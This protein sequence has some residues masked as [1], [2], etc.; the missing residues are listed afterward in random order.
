M[1]KVIWIPVLLLL[2]SCS[3]KPE[4]AGQNGKY[5]QLIMA[6]LYN[7]YAA[8]YRA[9]AYQAFNAA[10]WRVDRVANDQPDRSHLAIVLDIDETVLDNSP[11]QARTINT[12]IGYPACWDEWCNMAGAQ[13]VPGAVE[14]LTHADSLGFAIFYIS[15]RKEKTTYEGTARN[16]MAQGFPQ[17]DSEHLLLRSEPGG[18][19]PNPSDKEFRR[20]LLREKGYEIVLLA[21]D[22]LGDFFSDPQAG[23]DRNDMVNRMKDLYGSRFIIL[24]NAMYGNWPASVGINDERKS[25]DSLLHIMTVKL[26]SACTIIN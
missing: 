12:G 14:F 1:K 25:I 7:Y 21:G 18:P 17:V 26:D 9:L 2:A 16:L 22:N 5:D 15:N 20:N 3:N 23:A 6:T 8:E 13:A 24:P 4:K 10:T 11:Y 19:D